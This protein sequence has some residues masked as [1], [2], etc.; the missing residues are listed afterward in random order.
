MLEAG[1]PRQY[2]TLHWN[3]RV[4]NGNF[5]NDNNWD[6]EF[7]TIAI[8]DNT[9][10]IVKTGT[11]YGGFVFDTTFRT[12]ANHIYFASL[13][14][15]E[16]NASLVGMYAYPTSSYTGATTFAES[17][18]YG[19]ITNV[20]KI[21]A[22]KRLAIRCGVAATAVGSDCTVAKCMINDL[23]DMFGAGNEPSKE[24]FLR[25]FPYDYYN[26]NSGEYIR[27]YIE[28]NG[29]FSVQPSHI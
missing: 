7:S 15:L 8:S 20:V 22:T 23:T 21:T 18:S 25:M 1:Q 5:E 4:I 3:Q 26:Y 27:G 14:I 13:V 24:D 10:N 19:K 6:A 11:R 16:N 12:I 28:K 9:C 29:M 2:L 17:S